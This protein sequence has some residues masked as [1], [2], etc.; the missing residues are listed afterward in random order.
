[1]RPGRWIAL[2]AHSGVHRAAKN[3]RRG[4]RAL[5]GSQGPGLGGPPG[6]ELFPPPPEPSR[7]GQPF[8]FSAAHPRTLKEGPSAWDPGATLESARRG[9]PGIW[10][11]RC[12]GGPA[13]ARPAGGVPRLRAQGELGRPFPPTPGPRSRHRSR[14]GWLRSAPPGSARRSTLGSA[15][16]HALAYTSPRASDLNSSRSAAGSWAGVEKGPGNWPAGGGLETVCLPELPPSLQGG[17][18]RDLQICTWRRRSEDAAPICWGC[19]PARPVP[20]L[21]ALPLCLIS[22]SQLIISKAKVTIPL[23]EDALS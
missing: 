11:A 6:I 22:S 17:T 3:R 1:M 19:L 15:G 18:S 10:P 4:L 13:G 12:G 5:P 2:G 9:G 23:R 20:R 21:F 8:A 7:P 14:R 16:D